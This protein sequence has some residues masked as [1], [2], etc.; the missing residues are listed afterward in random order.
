MKKF[1]LRV[2]IVVVPIVL[3]VSMVLAINVHKEGLSYTQSLFETEND[4]RLKFVDSTDFE[5]GL[6]STDKIILPFEILSAREE[7]GFIVLETYENSIILAPADCVVNSVNPVNSETEL[8]VGNITVI[9]SNIVSGVRSGNR[10]ACGDVIGTVK[11]S[12]CLLKVF[13]GERKLS[14]DE[15][16]AVI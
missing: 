7:G 14:L 2:S 3:C 6:G 11:A 12:E 9:L 16:R 8:Q 13:W 1:I 5:L 4:Y 15:I 10:L